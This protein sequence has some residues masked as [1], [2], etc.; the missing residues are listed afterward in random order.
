MRKYN[1]IDGSDGKKYLF[2]TPDREQPDGERR[3]EEESAN[4]SQSPAPKERLF[5]RQ[6][7]EW[8][9]C[10]EDFFCVGCSG[11]AARYSGRSIGNCTR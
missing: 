6:I 7:S 1:L 9:S 3:L 8:E 10:T 2:Y 4:T 11:I 5:A